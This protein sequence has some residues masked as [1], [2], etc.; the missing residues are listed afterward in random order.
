[1]I[2]I[3]AIYVACAAASLLCA[4]LLLRGYLSEGQRLLF[5][6]SVCFFCFTVNNVLLF[7]DVILLPQVDLFMARSL[8]ALAGFGALLYGLIWE[9]L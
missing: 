1:M 5:W 7:I 6:V 2:I 4:L 8:A 3:G 9:G